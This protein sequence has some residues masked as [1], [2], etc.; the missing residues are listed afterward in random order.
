MDM[1]FKKVIFVSFL[2]VLAVV[3]VSCEKKRY[4]FGIQI[5]LKEKTLGNG[6]KVILVEDHQIPIV[7][8]QTWFRVGSV[9]EK[10]GY[11][12]IAHLFEHLMFKG[13]EKYGP[14]S[15]FNELESKGAEVNAFTARDYTVYY[16]NFTPNLLSK[17]IDLESDRLQNLKVTKELLLT[18]KQVVF[19]E[20]KLRVDNSPSGKMQEI[21][22]ALAYRVHPYRT[23]V[24]GNPIDLTRIQV[25]HLNEFFK[26]YYQPSNAAIVVV[27]D[28]DSDEVFRQI[29]KAYGGIPHIETPERKI[30]S[31]PTQDAE[32][33]IKIY[34]RVASYQFL[35]GYHVTR[36]AN[37][38]SYSLDVLANIL[39]AGTSSRGYRRLVEEKNLLLGLSGSAFTPTYPGLFMISGTVKGS[40]DT[41]L[42][43]KELDELIYEVQ[44][45]L[46]SREEVE[47]AVRQLLMDLVDG[48]RTPYGLG[49]LLGT[50]QS[51]L[52]N[53][54]QYASD[55]EK[56]FRVTPESVQA[57][58]LKYLR[59]NNRSTVV[60][61][62]HE[63]ET[64]ASSSKK[65][66]RKVQEKK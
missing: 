63:L 55:V 54:S 33:R 26:K 24:I 35:Q 57:V 47:I 25:K 16:Q 31:E 2:L 40:G 38:E 30:V 6:L 13:T 50:V 51:I 27:G 8:Y 46:V 34:D 21:L 60:M 11:T 4:P 17:V 52:G 18:E 48:I 28:I 43:E 3:P 59:P 64:E 61:I 39:F 44:S 65:S 15:F 56:Y 29:E 45:R 37:D 66:P 62:P 42:A 32:R 36:A 7:S 41:I 10:P 53:P 9:D 12:G 1:I 20:R 22:W 19:E 14:K 49:Q 58:A 23:P 5:E